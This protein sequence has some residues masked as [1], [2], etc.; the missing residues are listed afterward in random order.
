MNSFVF[1]LENYNSQ[2]EFQDSIKNFIMLSLKNR[3]IMTIRQEENGI[4]VIDYAS[5]YQ[6]LG[7]PYPYWLTPE[8]I[9][10]VC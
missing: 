1:C 10:R 3:Y 5:Q 8:Q 7:E 9:E 4:V 6:E 2:K